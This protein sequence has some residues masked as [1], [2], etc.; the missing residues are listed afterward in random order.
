M[1]SWPL[2]RL[3]DLTVNLDGRRRPIKE[4]ERKRGPYP[5]YGASGV[6]D[7]VDGYIFEGEHLLVAEDGENLRTRQ[8]PYVFRANGR[9]WVNNHA[10]VVIGNDRASTRYLEYALLAAD[11]S[12]FLSGA[13]MPKLTQANLNK[14][15][16]PEPTLPEQSAIVGIL[17]ALD[18]RI[19]LLRETN[20]TLEAIAQA[21]F[22]SWFVDFDPVRAKSE[23]RTPKGMDAAAAA[24]FPDTFQD[25]PLGPIPSGWRVSR[26]EDLMT[27]AYGRALK[28][29]DRLPGSVPVYGSGGITGSHDSSLV[30]GPGVIVGRKGT[31]GSLYWEDRNFYPI[32]TVFFVEPHVP[33]TFCYYLLRCLGLDQMNTDAAVPGLN[34]SNVYRLEVAAGPI[35]LLAAFNTLVA[36]IRRSIASRHE[37]ARS[38][39]EVR[40]FLLPK[41]V[42]GSIRIGP[43]DNDAVDR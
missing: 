7:S 11:I 31:V 35:A 40:D 3:G 20:A 42:S 10:H 8:T 4:S 30:A 32:D 21:L 26:V 23:G 37:A 16:V 41:L 38:L 33:L 18:D 19:E 34:R 24:L 1:S 27:L 17:G 2:T 28:A 29:T 43:N 36:K 5:Y 25:S 13:V 6:V 39:Q 14:I 9:F 22:K 12:G 15:E